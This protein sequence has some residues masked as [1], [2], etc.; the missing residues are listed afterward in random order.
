MRS[1]KSENRIQRDP[2]GLLIINAF[3]NLWYFSKDRNA[4]RDD[5]IC[6]STLFVA[7]L[8]HDKERTYEPFTDIK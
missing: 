5:F 2:I 3:G 8:Y 6:G 7:F 4:W 1:A